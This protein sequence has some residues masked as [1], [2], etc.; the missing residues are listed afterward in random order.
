MTKTIIEVFSE[1]EEKDHIKK[2]TET[3]YKKISDCMWT[4][5]YKKNQ[6]EIVISREW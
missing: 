2:L 1:T 6:N 3:G 5:I 4:K